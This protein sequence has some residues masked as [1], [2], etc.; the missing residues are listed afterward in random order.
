MTRMRVIT[1]TAA[2]L[3]LLAMA[4]FAMNSTEVRSNVATVED[5][6]VY[7]WGPQEFAGF[8]YGI[9]D[10]I[11]T[12]SI[13]LTITGD[14]L[15]EPEGVVYETVAQRD[16]FDYE[17]WG[18]YW[19]IGF[20]GEEYFAAYVE[21]DAEDAYLFDDSTDDNL[22]ID[23]QLS[24]VLYNDDEERTFTTSTPL[25]LA[26]GYELEIKTTDQ[27][28]GR[29]YVQLTKDGVVVDSALV[30]PSKYGATI[31]DKTYTYKK[32]LGDTEKIV[33]IAVHFKNAFRGAGADLATIDGIW[34]I[35]D[36]YTDVEEDTEYDK[37]TIQTVDADALAIMMNNEDNK[38]DLS[39]NKYTPLMGNIWIKTA[40]Q[41]I[42]SAE[43]PLR[44]YICKEITEPGNYE[45]RGS[46]NCVIDG[47]MM[48]WNPSNFAGLYYDIDNNLGTEKITISLWGDTLEEPNGVVYTT[49]AQIDNFEFQDWGSFYA[50]AFMGQL[51]F[52]GYIDDMTSDPILDEATT[53]N[54]LGSGCLSKIL[55]DNSTS[56]VIGSGET[57]ELA[58]GYE[59]RPQIG[60]DDKAILV[61][62]LH[63]GFVIDQMA[64]L[65]PVT[66]V[67]STDL[68]DALGVPIIA[69]HF[70]EPVS[71]DDRSYCKIDGLWQI[72]D[73]PISIEE[74]A[75]YD[76]M[77]VQSIDPSSMN[78]M[79][80]N[81]D[82]KITLN[83]NMGTTL[84]GDI[85]IK[86]ADQDWLSAENPLRFYIYKKV[87]VQ[88][89]E[90]LI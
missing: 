55:V 76:K 84:M 31:E 56:M 3:L 70:L 9:D 33:V 77:T 58:E 53:S 46:V 90:E 15:E 47:Y 59:L 89:S 5:G 78:I 25:K 14:A 64:V 67:Y 18:T 85:R 68:G 49:D 16:D 50:M 10:N 34:Q 40:N 51:Y 38:I 26:E 43:E 63:D 57:V 7:T 45:I 66:Y 52:A 73:S 27:S 60:I 82:N 23:E 19:T 65:P 61:E 30:E 36:T 1:F 74:D 13:T 29:V 2:I 62:L 11:G 17:E 42:I 71:L 22:M 37:M 21:G 24:K 4:A 79:M 8:Y 54:L 75:I 88:G 28:T 83:K 35:S 69:A 6:A 86:T 81:E 12:E 87:T 41:D 32:D 39:A 72:S 48:E 20:L 44:F 80:N